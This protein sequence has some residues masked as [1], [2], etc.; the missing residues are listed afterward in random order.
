MRAR[1]TTSINWDEGGIVVY[2]E[3]V[4]GENIA[5]HEYPV[6]RWSLYAHCSVCTVVLHEKFV[7]AEECNAEWSATINIANSRQQKSLSAENCN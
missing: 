7:V 1:K 5:I 6:M 4:G 3:G 2:C